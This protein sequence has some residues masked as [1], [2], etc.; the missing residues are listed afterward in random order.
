MIRVF[1]FLPQDFAAY[2][3]PK[4][5]FSDSCR[6]KSPLTTG[7]NPIFLILTV[8][9]CLSL[10]AKMTELYFLP[11]KVTKIYGTKTGI[12]CFGRS[13]IPISTGQHANLLISAVETG[14]RTRP[15]ITDRLRRW[16]S[17]IQAGTFFLHASQK[18]IGSAPNNTL[19]HFSKHFVLTA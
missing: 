4:S 19:K 15:V 2:Y 8:E 1:C 6:R 18:G 13:E 16:M 5:I 7:Q 12:S 17:R 9:Y 14:C 11:Y 3:G 10:R